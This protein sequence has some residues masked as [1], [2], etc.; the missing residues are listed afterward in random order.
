MDMSL[1]LEQLL[2]VFARYNLAIWPMQIVAYVLGLVGLIL[3]ARQTRYRNK[4]I[5]GI[6]SFLWLWT[7]IAFFLL[8]FG[9]VYTPAYA[10][11]VLFIL[12]GALFLYSA[13]KPQLSFGFRADAYGI[14]GI[15]FIVYAM[16]GYPV[17]G[18][19][20]GHVYPQS[21]PFGLTPCPSAVFTFGLFL[22]TDKKAPRLFLAIPFLWA[23]SGVI[24]VSIGVFED[25]GL[26][27]AGVV[28]TAMVLYRD[29]Q[30]HGGELQ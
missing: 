24:P 8:Y 10:F 16:I 14:V 23:L 11:G 20:L 30:R 2:D 5:A 27:T 9:P 17:L 21:P 26:I 25:V 1:T 3:A 12:Q 15:L 28:G 29:S 6:L 19:L 18:I 13:V 22:L 7:G 4:V